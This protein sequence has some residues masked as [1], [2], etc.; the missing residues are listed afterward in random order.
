MFDWQKDAELLK[1]GPF[2]F[3]ILEEPI[4]EPITKLYQPLKELL[5]KIQQAEE[6]HRPK[7]AAQKQVQK[8]SGLLSYFFK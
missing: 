2:E 8:K 6:V 3:R 7:L 1:N 4:Q 5:L